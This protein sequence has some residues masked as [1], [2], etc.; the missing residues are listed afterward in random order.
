MVQLSHLYMTT[1]KTIAW[2]V[3]LASMEIQEMSKRTTPEFS[4]QWQ[5]S[6]H[7]SATPSYPLGISTK[8]SLH[9]IQGWAGSSCALYACWRIEFW[10]TS[11]L[12]ILQVS[13]LRVDV[14]GEACKRVWLGTSLGVQWLRICLLMQGIWAQSLVRELLI[15]SQVPW[16]NW[17][18]TTE[19]AYS[20]AHALWEED[21]VHYNWREAPHAATESLWATVKTQ[22][23]SAPSPKKDLTVL[24]VEQVQLS[25]TS[26]FL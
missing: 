23:S 16:G 19:P 9:E 3:N 15:R 24:P 8:Q 11:K 2:R 20:R 14:L 22:H 6:A 7:L 17:A 12:C 21:L 4:L 18:S 25:W 26:F 10:K 5:S 13:P 1:G